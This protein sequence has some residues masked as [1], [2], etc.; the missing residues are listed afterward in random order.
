MNLQLSGERIKEMRNKAGLTQDQLAAKLSGIETS[1]G[2]ST[3]SEYEHGK[4]LTLNNLQKLADV[5][6]CDVDYLLGCIDHPEITTSWIAEKVPMSRETIEALEALNDI[7][8]DTEVS[9]IFDLSIGLIENMI[10]A[11][12]PIEISGDRAT[13]RSDGLNLAVNLSRLKK[14]YEKKNQYRSSLEKRNFSNLNPEALARATQAMDENALNDTAIEA[15]RLR[16]INAFT[17]ILDEYIKTFS[18]A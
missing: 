8:H 4:N 9:E 13:V 15:Y 6:P 18:E 10:I 16:I 3:I 5:L 7:S 11:I 17:E 1:R 12:K 2:K 14:A